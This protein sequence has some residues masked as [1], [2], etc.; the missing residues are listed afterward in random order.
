MLEGRHV[1]TKEA[2]GE[3]ILERM[4]CRKEWDIGMKGTLE[5]RGYWH[6][7]KRERKDGKEGWEGRMGRK[8]GK[9][10]KGNAGRKDGKE[11][12]IGRKGTLEGR[13]H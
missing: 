12:D 11:G 6:E 7:R 1:G 13:G 5:G 10:E 3:V 4:E 8:D 9:E 2:W